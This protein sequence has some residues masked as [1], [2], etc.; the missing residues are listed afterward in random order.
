MVFDRDDFSLRKIETELRQAPFDALL[1]ALE[2]AVA[3]E[4]GVEGA[5][6]GVPVALGVMPARLVGEADG[7]EGNGD[8]GNVLRL[9]AGEFQA[10]T[11]GFVGHAVLGM[12]VAHE[13]FFFSGG[14]ELAVDVQGCRRVVG[15][16]AGK[17]EDGQ[18]HVGKRCEG[19][20]AMDFR[21][22]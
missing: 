7:R 17:A 19:G 13:A 10:E 11:G 20:G 22:G 1:V 5:V 18:G 3:G 6:R 16:G 21:G 15:E 4:Q 2:A 12:L 8:G 14:D 9:D